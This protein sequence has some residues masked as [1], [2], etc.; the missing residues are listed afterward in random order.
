[1]QGKMAGLETCCRSGGMP[2]G[3]MYDEE[4]TW[5]RQISSFDER[6]YFGRMR[7]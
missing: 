1:V 2:H 6:N 7:T 4:S 5:H 3:A